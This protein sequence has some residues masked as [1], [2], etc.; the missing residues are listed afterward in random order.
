MTTLDY[1]LG[2]TQ[3]VLTA[4]LVAACRTMY[5]KLRSSALTYSRVLEITLFAI[6]M[7][8]V[9]LLL[10]FFFVTFIVP[11]HFISPVAIWFYH[12]AFPM[13]VAVAF[14]LLLFIA[15]LSSFERRRSRRIVL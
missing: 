5:R 11:Q 12:W 8:P 3:P 2:L 6:P 14:V 4:V 7:V 10:W 9:S 13:S 15:L 1:V